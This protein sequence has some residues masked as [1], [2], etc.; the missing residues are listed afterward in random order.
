MRKKT[1][2]ACLFG[3]HCGSMKICKHFSPL[4]DDMNDVELGVY[5]ENKRREYLRDWWRYI[6]DN[7]KSPSFPESTIL[8]ELQVR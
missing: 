1:C 4:D 6:G 5:I 3:D 2:S 8:N 7:D